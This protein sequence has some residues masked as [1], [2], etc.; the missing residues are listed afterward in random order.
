[1]ASKDIHG[2]PN[3]NL[4]CNKLP[5]CFPLILPFHI[6]RNL[7]RIVASKYVI[8][9]TGEANKGCGS[10]GQVHMLLIQH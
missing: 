3:C 10:E 6:P 5:S 9:A 1:M 2:I 8:F 4:K 7:Q